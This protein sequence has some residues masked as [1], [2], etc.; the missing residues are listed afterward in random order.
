MPSRTKQSR[1]SWLS[2]GSILRVGIAIILVCGGYIILS[3]YF[4]NSYTQRLL[5]VRK[6][7]LQRIVDLGLAS[8]EPFRNE[9][10]IDSGTSSMEQ[11]RR[12]GAITLREMTYRYRLDENYLFM[13]TNS[14]VVL[15]QPFEQELEYTNQY[16]LTDVKGTYFVREMIEVATAEGQGFVE[17]WYVPPGC[18]VPER[19]ISYIVNIPE[20]NALVGAGMYMGDIEADN[21]AY[22]ITSLLL[23]LGVLLLILGIVWLALRPIAMSYR[24]LI[25]LFRQVRHEPDTL[26][27]VPVA[28]FRPGSE[29]WHLLHDFQSMLDQI[30][31]HKRAH[32][33]AT[34]A[35][36]NRLAREL[37][38]AVSQTL[39]SAGLI[40]D[41]LPSLLE[42]QPDKAREQI[43]VLGEL[44]HG[45]HAELR[46]LLVELRP[47]RLLQAELGELIQQLAQ[48]I[49]GRYRLPVDTQV[50]DVGPLP[51]DIKIALY[52]ITQE[53]LTNAARHAA[54]NR[55]TVRLRSIEDTLTLTIEDDG[56]GFDPQHTPTGHFGLSIMRERAEA[57]GSSLALDSMKGKGT[58]LMLTCPLPSL[59]TRTGS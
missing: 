12:D 18:D 28:D 17:Y 30:A 50:E 56:Q 37:H 45:A 26:P 3:M 46:T 51:A 8:L 13:I 55:V 15:V 25:A 39:F 2:S 20:W 35:E 6:S 49:T 27:A 44:T 16:D 11:L 43:K 5:D 40:A 48:A 24:I 54:A 10:Y 41:V 23:A 14:G 57:I 42:K 7:E 22:A 31:R 53:A 21:Q 59:S 47:E 9:N 1:S 36:R 58:T 32:Q 38:D 33:E 29:A 52:R 19:K 4:I 34:L